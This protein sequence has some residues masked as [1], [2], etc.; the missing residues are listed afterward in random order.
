[1]HVSTHAGGL[2]VSLGDLIGGEERHVVVRVGFP[3]EASGA[4]PTIRARLV[5]AGGATDWQE[6]AFRYADHDDCDAE[7]RDMPVMRR[8]AAQHADRVRR[9]AA[10]RSSRGDTRGAREAIER[11][12]RRIPGYAGDDREL[13][14]LL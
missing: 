13:L 2:A 1:Y 14:A 6:V 8:V 4:R 5:W 7:P 11:V 9:E 3:A 12:A 10:Q